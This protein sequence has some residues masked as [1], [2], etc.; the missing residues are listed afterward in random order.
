M[1][2]GFITL[3]HGEDFY[4]RWT[5]YELILKIVISELSIIEK[6]REFSNWLK[7]MLPRYPGDSRIFDLRGL[8]E[9]NRNLFWC[10]VEKGVEKIAELGEKY[11][12]LNKERIFLLLYMHKTNPFELKFIKEDD[13]FLFTENEYI[14]KIGPGWKNNVKQ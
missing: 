4:T 8:T 3:E 5:G 9:E 1:A 2:N 12:P 6:G 11:S 14:E 10:G 7:T 13:E